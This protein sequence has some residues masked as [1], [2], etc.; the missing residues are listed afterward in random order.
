MAT[1]KKAPKPKAAKPKAVVSKSKTTVKAKAATKPKAIAKPKLAIKP[2]AKAV[3]KPK[4]KVVKK[5]KVQLT[6]FEIMI[7]RISQIPQKERVISNHDFEIA[8]QQWLPVINKFIARWKMIWP[9]EQ[10]K[11]TANVALW[12]ALKRYKKEFK[13]TTYLY[14][15]MDWEYMN[16]KRMIGRGFNYGLL[17]KEEVYDIMTAKE[18]PEFDSSY[19]MLDTIKKYL[20]E[21]EKI[22][23]EERIKGMQFEQIA[24]RLKVSRQRSH[25]M[26]AVIQQKVMRLIM[27]KKIVVG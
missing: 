24:S 2:K 19:E 21:N 11:Q 23:L 8:R 3:A 13:F 16:Q 15:C 12:N 9:I 14:N 22:I 18:D 6:E 1:V 4:P 27:E 10:A 20:T 26:L 17:E 5:P 25:Q 7:N